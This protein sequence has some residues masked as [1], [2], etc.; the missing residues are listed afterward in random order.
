MDARLES[1]APEAYEAAV[2]EVTGRIAAGE[3]FQANIARRWRGRLPA[4]ARPFDLFARLAG[5]SPAPFAAYLRLA[6]R[7]VVSNSPERFVSVEPRAGGL[8]A[9]TQPI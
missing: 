9:L 4:D 7:A 1:D 3:I 2:A 5:E 6:D 8:H